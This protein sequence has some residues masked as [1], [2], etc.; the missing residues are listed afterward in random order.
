MLK[1]II[2]DDEPLA[3]SLMREMLE[4]LEMVQIVDECANGFEGLKSVQTHQPD[5]IFL[6]V[7]MPK[8]NGFE[9]LE[10]IE[11]PPSVI[12]VT[13]FDEY[14]V[15]AFDVNAIDYLLKPI[16]PARLEKAIT[17]VVQQQ[18]KAG[19]PRLMEPAPHIMLPEQT[20]RVV[21]KEQG[22]IK[23]IPL[24]K[25]LF[26]EA[27]DDYVKVHTKEKYF[28]KYQTMARFEQQ[29]PAQQFV[30]IHRSYI[31]NVSFVN[32]I[33]LLEKEQYTVLLNNGQNIPVSKSGYTKLKTFLGI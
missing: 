13:A 18:G 12:F 33:E 16:E 27:A 11:H 29:L 23:I 3:R 14:A 4:P 28:L 25:I 32:K 6:D 26:L 30:R 17:K 21:V 20:Q 22:E 8:I 9:M 10:L 7:Q 1:C 2:I 15:Q 31:V 24:D 5:L 19:E